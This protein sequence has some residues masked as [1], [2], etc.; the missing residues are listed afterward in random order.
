MKLR[1]E[2]STALLEHLEAQP[3]AWAKLPDELVDPV[4]G[5]P[6]PIGTV[7]YHVELAQQADYVRVMNTDRTKPSPSGSAAPWPIQA[8]FPNLGPDGTLEDDG[9]QP[10]T[11]GIVVQLTWNGHN[12]LD[13]RKAIGTTT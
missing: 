5:I 7:C 2:V 10:T 4:S 6:L 8:L 11:T 12:A 1:Q 3:T 13:V 9:R